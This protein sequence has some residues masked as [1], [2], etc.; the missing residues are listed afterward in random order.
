VS[1]VGTLVRQGQMPATLILDDCFY[2]SAWNRDVNLR[3]LFGRC[4][5]IVTM[6]YPL[7]IHDVRVDYAFILSASTVTAR[8]RLYEYYAV[9][10][11]TFDQ[12]CALLDQCTGDNECIV[13]HTSNASD[14]IEDKLFWY[15][16][17]E[18]ASPPTP[19]KSSRR[20][21]RY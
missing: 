13:I 9:G 2:D 15:K 16:E 12:F 14:R 4:Q 5:C 21:D 20:P 1:Q 7:P 18:P 10:I 6:Q 3:Y 8:R 11:V 17:P 19:T